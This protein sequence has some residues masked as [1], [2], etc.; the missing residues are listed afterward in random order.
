MFVLWRLYFKTT[1]PA[2]V[3]IEQSQRKTCNAAGLSFIYSGRLT[4]MSNSLTQDSD[5]FYLVCKK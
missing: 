2:S 4:R 3:Q 5:D 1:A